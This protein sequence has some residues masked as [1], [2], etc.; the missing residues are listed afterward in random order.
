M[1]KRQTDLPETL[2]PAQ[3]LS[4]DTVQLDRRGLLVRRL[5]GQSTQIVQGLGSGVSL[6]LISIPSGYFRMGSLHEGGYDDEQPVHPV[7]LKGFWLGKYPI[8]QAQWQVVMGH[9][10]SCRFHG[11]NLPVD[12]ICWREAVFFCQRLAR[13]T[14][15]PYALPAE[16][17]WEY[18][19]RAGTTT[20]FNFGE[21]ITTD[22]VNY[23]GDHTYRE[24]QPG[25]YRHGTTPVG[26]FPPNLWGLYDMHGNV[27]EFCSDRWTENYAGASVDGMNPSPPIKFSRDSLFDRIVSSISQQVDFFPAAEASVPAY[28][29]ARGGSW[30]ETP[31]HCRSAVRLRVGENE[32][33][34]YYG[35]RVMLPAF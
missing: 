32:R 5:H 17:Q 20:P 33:L 12:T 30:H 29:V 9:L 25:V 34:E 2:S 31:A 26:S 35:F 21:N 27:W 14:G 11:E 6:E 24:S 8:T 4:V 28:R 18:A 16:A 23:V 1:H 7:Y 10:P 3:I 13:L 15:R 19:C 22:Q